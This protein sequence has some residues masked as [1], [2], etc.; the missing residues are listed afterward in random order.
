ME[1]RSDIRSF[2]DLEALSHAAAGIFREEAAR[3]ITAR[4]R[5]AVALSGGGT[6]RRTY[7]LL[8]TGQFRDRVNWQQVHIFWGDERGVPPEDSRSNYHLARKCLLERVPLPPEHIHPI[9]AFPSVALGAEKYETELKV[10]FGHTAPHF[11]LIFL[12]LGVDGHTASLFP[13]S[14]VLWEERRWVTGVSVPDQELARVTLTPWVINLAARVVFL[15][16]GKDKAEV[17]KVVLEGPR[18][19]LRYPAQLIRPLSKRLLWLAD[20][21]A[22]SL[23]AS[24]KLTDPKG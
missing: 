24:E 12:G 9:P 14:P 17:V 19:P 23:L 16:A 15:V 2:P 8:A 7:E 21:E 4:G 11:D 13:G 5:F 20:Q 18:D 10:F 6:P 22:A 3:S 1:A